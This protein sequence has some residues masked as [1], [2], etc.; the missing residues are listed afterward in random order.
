MVIS[1]YTIIQYTPTPITISIFEGDFF[2]ILW[3]QKWY[4]SWK[5]RS[6]QLIEISSVMKGILLKELGVA[7]Y[8][9]VQI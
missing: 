2:E 5:S 3:Y 9:E 6:I 8:L 7:L 1:Y 4:V